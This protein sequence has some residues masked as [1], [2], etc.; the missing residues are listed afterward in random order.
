MQYSISNT[1]QNNLLKKVQEMKEFHQNIKKL[2]ISDSRKC[3]Q[4]KLQY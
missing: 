4:R 3:L 2:L 1:M